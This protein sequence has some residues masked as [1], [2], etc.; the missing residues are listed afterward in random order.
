MKIIQNTKKNRRYKVTKSGLV[1]R[2]LSS[3]H[4]VKNLNFSSTNVEKNDIN[5][6]LIFNE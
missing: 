6:V 4:E 1:M 2:G 5:N 3:L